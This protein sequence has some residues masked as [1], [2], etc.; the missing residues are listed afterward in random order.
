MINLIPEIK[1]HF[2][3]LKEP[4]NCMHSLAFQSEGWFKVE[5]L[6][7]LHRLKQERRVLHFCREVSLESLSIQKITTDRRRIDV[8]ID[9][10]DGQKHWVEL[11]HW[12]IGKQ[13]NSTYAPIFYFSDR[14]DVGIIQDII[15]LNATPL[16]D[17]QWLMILMTKNPNV[18]AWNM[19]LEKFGERFPAYHLTSLTN[20]ADYP[21]HYFLG[22]LQVE[23][24]STR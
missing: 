1:S 24:T 4:L 5:L 22:L 6:T 20:P 11:K 16:T 17:N 21:D 19:G 2:N 13:K 9:T 8:V 18:E 3:P 14:K 7:L 12:L 15:K 10:M 23:I